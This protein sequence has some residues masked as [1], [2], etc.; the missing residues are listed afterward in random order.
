MKIKNTWGCGATAPLYLNRA[1]PHPHSRACDV[2]TSGIKP[3]HDITENWPTHWHPGFWFKR[4]C[5]IIAATLW[6]QKHHR[7]TAHHHENL[8]HLQS[9]DVTPPPLAPSGRSP[10]HNF[11]RTPLHQIQPS[12]LLPLTFCTH[13]PKVRLMSSRHNFFL[14]LLFCAWDF[15]KVGKVIIGQFLAPVVFIHYA[16][17]ELLSDLITFLFIFAKSTWNTEPFKDQLSA[18]GRL[19]FS[20]SFFHCEYYECF[21]LCRTDA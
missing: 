5:G 20:S 2:T 7:W 8:T 9:R 3:A 13:K 17:Q 11:L 15:F 10:L 18:G 14:P 21:L 1:L 16:Y 6:S 19:L 12:S 4:H